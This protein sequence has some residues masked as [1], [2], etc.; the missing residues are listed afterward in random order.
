MINQ[1][2]RQLVVDD[3]LSAPGCDREIGV[4]KLGVDFIRIQSCGVDDV[5]GVNF[6][7]QHPYFFIFRPE[8]SRRTITCASTTLS[9][10]G[11]YLKI[12]KQLD[13]VDDCLC[14]KGHGNRK[15]AENPLAR[16]QQSAESAFVDV[17]LATIDFIRRNDLYIQHAV[18]MRLLFQR[19]QGLQL[20]L[21]PGNQN[22]SQPF[23]RDVR[24]RHEFFH[25]C[26]T[27]AHEPG[28]ERAG[29]G[30][31]AGMPDGSAGL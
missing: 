19:G 23:V 29:L 8:R 17:R 15:G 2:T 10:N 5:A 31:E 7:I 21:I 30:V 22:R 14:R 12:Q 18:F 6:V 1:R 13:T 9:V 4:T 25:E 27:A 11:L 3:Q 28:F 26:V 16:D 20:L 24:L